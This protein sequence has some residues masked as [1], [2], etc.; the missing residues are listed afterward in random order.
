MAL[1][2]LEAIP[3]DA[4]RIAAIHLAAFDSNPLLHV[5]FPTP[6]SLAS[7]RDI[8]AQ[9]TLHSIENA[10]AG[11]KVVLVVRD[12]HSDNR[13]ISFA[14]WDLPGVH[15]ELPINVSWHDDV[16]LDFLSK[17]RELAEAAKQ[18]VVGNKECYCKSSVSLSLFL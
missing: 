12:P 10:E 18:R 17:Y 2:L 1:K 8:L 4:D 3:E 13:I 5:Q 16:N 7:L 6:A 15:Q 14:K 11:G 9:D